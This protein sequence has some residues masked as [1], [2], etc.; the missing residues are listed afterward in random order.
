MSNSDFYRYAGKKAPH[1]TRDYCWEK[2]DPIEPLDDGHGYYV[3]NGYYVPCYLP[4]AYT[5]GNGAAPSPD[6]KEK[7]ERYE[8]AL[9]PAARFF[10]SVE[11]ASDI[12]RS[13][14]QIQNLHAR[15]DHITQ[16]LYNAQESGDA[17]KVLKLRL[18]QESW[19][20][21][22]IGALVMRTQELSDAIL[23]GKADQP[24]KGEGGAPTAE[25]EIQGCFM[26]FLTKP[27]I[28]AH[29]KLQGNKPDLD[30]LIPEMLSE[31]AKAALN[32]NGTLTV[33]FKM[34][35]ENHV[36]KIGGAMKAID[37][38]FEQIEKV[39]NTINGSDGVIL[40]SELGDYIEAA[41]QRVGI[42][43][44]DAGH[45]EQA[46][47]QYKVARSM[48]SHR[49]EEMQEKSRPNLSL[50]K[51]VDLIK[52]GRLLVDEMCYYRNPMPKTL[53]LYSEK[54]AALL[55]QQHARGAAR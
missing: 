9:A 1:G 42:R 36:I 7:Q 4:K 21:L 51:K 22:Y 8:F 6:D 3:V 35:H 23:H 37:A 41:R 40:R 48:V 52:E 39:A 38:T 27:D 15:Y 45:Y 53:A 33:P 44:T 54:V 25:E 49:I 55:Q 18:T 24:L 31:V 12:H 5:N 46:H 20:A 29:V 2:N 10:G 17:E 47:A 28:C 34:L 50:H 26:V 32:R 16:E 19:G 14:Q 43:S 11:R 13:Y 30:G